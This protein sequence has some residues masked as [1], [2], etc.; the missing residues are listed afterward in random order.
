[1]IGILVVTHEHLCEHLIRCA[2]H[3]LGERPAQLQSLSVFVEND[4]DD[5]LIN[6]RTLTQKLDT[7]DGVLI[8]CDILGAT[9]C[10]IASRLI[11]RD[12][13]A[14]ITG[15]NLPML[16]RALTYRNE[17]LAATVNKALDG[18]INGV[19]EIS[20]GNDHAA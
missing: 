4:P 17:T 7:G 16:V 12:R 3:V 18:G 5:V 13:V 20:A 1:M 15:I 8:L 9:P 19:V 10:N 11:R 6:M 2:C 14:C